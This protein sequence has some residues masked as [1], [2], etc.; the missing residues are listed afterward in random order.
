MRKES[1]AMV[2]LGEPVKVN[3]ISGFL[4]ILIVMQLT[5]MALILNKTKQVYAE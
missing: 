2:P 4:T 5:L 3:F 1:I